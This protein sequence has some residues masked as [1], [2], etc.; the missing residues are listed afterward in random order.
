MY[1]LDLLQPIY[2]GS[3]LESQ[4]TR[5]LDAQLAFFRQLRLVRVRIEE[6]VGSFLGGRPVARRGLRV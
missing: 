4:A 3:A 2:I 5:L 1:D 6:L